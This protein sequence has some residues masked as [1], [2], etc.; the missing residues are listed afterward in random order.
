[1]VGDAVPALSSS[2]LGDTANYSA[3]DS[4]ACRCCQPAVLPFSAEEGVTF[5]EDCP[6]A[7]KLDEH[8]VQRSVLDGM[9][10]ERDAYIWDTKPN[11]A[12]VI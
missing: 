12:R 9:R 2:Y 7:S 1:M 5:P 10:V 11:V 3:S 6:A 4:T 8:V